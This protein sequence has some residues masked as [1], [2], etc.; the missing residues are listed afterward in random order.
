M[1]HQRCLQSKHT[2]PPASPTLGLV[3][4]PYCSNP[5]GDCGGFSSWDNPAPH[6]ECACLGEHYFSFSP[7]GHRNIR[8]GRNWVVTTALICM[9]LNCYLWLVDSSQSS[10]RGGVQP[11]NLSSCS[12]RTH[13]ACHGAA[14]KSPERQVVTLWLYNTNLINNSSKG[15]KTEFK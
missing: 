13:L 12:L 8:P 9:T 4:A 11:D 2:C 15:D 1:P 5:V 6:V 10:L 14:A 3:S 7:L